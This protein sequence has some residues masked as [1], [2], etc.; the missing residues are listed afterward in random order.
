MSFNDAMNRILPPSSGVFAH[1]TSDFGEN[2]VS[3]PHG[4]VDFNYQGGQSGINLTN[5]AIN[6]PIGGTVIFVGGQYGTIKIKDKQG[7]SHEIL[8]TNSQHVRIGQQVSAGDVIGTMGGSG[9][10]GP[11]QYPQHVHYQMKDL[12]GQLI[13]PQAWWDNIDAVG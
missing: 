10:N 9:P 6:S 5:P 13:N 7:N 12:Q 11:D 2:R 3:G 8:H 1:I 4:G